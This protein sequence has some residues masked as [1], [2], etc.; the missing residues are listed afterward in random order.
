M[1]AKKVY[2][3]LFPVRKLRIVYGYSSPTGFFFSIPFLT[4]NQFFLSK[5]HH[6]FTAGSVNRWEKH[7]S[8]SQIPLPPRVVA[9]LTAVWQPGSHPPPLTFHPFPCDFCSYYN[10]VPPPSP[11]SL[12]CNNL[13]QKGLLEVIW[14]KPLFKSGQFFFI[15]FFLVDATKIL[16]W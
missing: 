6:K 7:I 2:S 12:L 11:K 4:W 14:S 16:F 9:Q 1:C 8:V 3:C 13:G 5:P 15:I 10:C